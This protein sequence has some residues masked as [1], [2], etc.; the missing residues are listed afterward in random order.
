MPGA[1]PWKGVIY[2]CCGAYGRIYQNQ[3]TLKWTGNCPKCYKPVIMTNP[4]LGK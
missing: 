2:S 1:R 4:D 3:N